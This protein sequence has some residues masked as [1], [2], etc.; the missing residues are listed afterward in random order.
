MD[1]LPVEQKEYETE[2][3]ESLLP[4]IHRLVDDTLLEIILN[5]I[6]TPETPSVLPDQ[7]HAAVTFGRVCRRWRLLALSS[8]HLWTHFY[9]DLRHDKNYQYM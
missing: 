7:Q 1:Q 3:P 6:P 4:P 2:A 8:P 9:V 5:L